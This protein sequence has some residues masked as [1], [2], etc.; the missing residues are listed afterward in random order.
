MT[1]LEPVGRMMNGKREF[2]ALHL[3]NFSSLPTSLPLSSP[4]FV[5]LLAA[6]ATGTDSAAITDLGRQLLS[7]GCV[8]FCTWGPDC[9]RVHDIFD[10]ECFEVEPVIMTTWHS[11]ETLDE[12]LWFFAFTAFPD[13]R[14][15]GT[16]TSALAISIG[17]TTWE[18]LI[19]RR[20]SNLE[21]LDRDVVHGA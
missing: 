1:N 19:R 4:H 11:G 10:E 13:S 14:Y 2:F 5:A 21:E 18:Q 15:E 16:C 9:E 3:A 20:L 7:A 6:D 12:A 8:Y 17:N